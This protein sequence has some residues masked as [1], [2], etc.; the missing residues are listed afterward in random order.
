MKKK[1]TV[2]ANPL[3][4]LLLVDIPTVQRL[5]GGESR[6]SIYRAIQRGE[7]E[8]VKLGR[9][10]KLT[11]A[12]VSARLKMLRAP[13]TNRVPAASKSSTGEE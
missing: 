3:F 8:V 1:S 11:L 6:S 5:G 9:S 4:G 2:I 12:S 13:N 7:L 10:T